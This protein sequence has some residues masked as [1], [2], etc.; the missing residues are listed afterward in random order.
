M[1]AFT[2]AEGSITIKYGGTGLGLVISKSLVELM[3]GELKVESEYGKGS[4]FYFT[5]TLPIAQQS[6]VPKWKSVSTFRKRPGL[7]T[8]LWT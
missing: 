5:L 2:Q 8:R 1:A 7:L 6:S 4:R 3:G